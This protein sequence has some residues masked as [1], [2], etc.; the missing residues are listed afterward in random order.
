VARDMLT[1]GSGEA[2]T[3][4]SLS[5]RARVSRR[6]LYTHWGTVEQLIADAV[7]VE[8][9]KIV[10]TDPAGLSARERLSTHL[11]GIR[12][13]L[14]QPLTRVALA[15]LIG[16]APIDAKAAESLAG[17]NASR[18]QQFREFV[19]PVTQ[20]QYNQLVGPLF[21]AEFVV[22][23]PASDEQVHTIAEYGSTL[24]D[25]GD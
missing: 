17:M 24:L 22:G 20:D 2:L 21:L 4:S 19:G 9:A 13:G 23:E 25:L 10:P 16:Q 15:S 11:R 18:L 6:T 12:D 1:E 3:F 8:H 14:M 7:D 5:E